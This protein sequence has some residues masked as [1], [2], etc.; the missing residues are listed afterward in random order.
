[1]SGGAQWGFEKEVTVGGEWNRRP[2][3]VLAKALATLSVLACAFLGINLPPRTR[4]A[5]AQEETV[6][7][8]EAP[9]EGVS[10]SG[11]VYFYLDGKLT[12]VARDI[13]A[14]GQMTEFA[15]MELLN[16][17]KEEERAAG[18]VTYIPEGVK[19]QYTNVK[20]DRTEFTVNLS[21]ELLNLSKDRQAA[22]RALAQLVKTIREITQ[23]ENV[24]VTVASEQAEAKYEDAFSALG[25]SRDDVEAEMGGKRRQ[26]ILLWLVLL[27]AVGV[28]A[29]AG[30]IALAVL[31]TVSRK[32]RAPE[33]PVVGT[34]A[35]PTL[36]VKR[37]E[38]SS[39]PTPAPWR[40]PRRRKRGRKPGKH[41]RRPSP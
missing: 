5:L 7:E 29:L 16:G 27:L 31:G 22:V 26:R 41:E 11:Q 13:V 21:R 19:L 18:Y 3:A 15:I 35:R 6:P 30:A 24:L 40:E 23:I 32:R 12:P 1:M 17:P 4:L 8:G 37:K 10:S 2:V 33:R 25:V 36:R 9:T 14:G 39:P 38:G 28:P 34:A 20:N